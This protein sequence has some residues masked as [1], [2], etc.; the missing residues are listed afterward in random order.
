VL[1]A[2]NFVTSLLSDAG[3][4]TPPGVFSFILAHAST[5]CEIETRLLLD[6]AMRGEDTILI[7]GNNRLDA[8]GLLARARAM[9]IEDTLADGVH[10]ARAFT[11][12]QFLTLLEETLP[13][14]VHE[15]GARY[16]LVTGLLE[17]FSDEDVTEAEARV[18]VPRTLQRLTTFA[19]HAS[20]P[21]VA[22][23]DVRSRL[24]ALA[25]EHT[26]HREI[27]L[28]SN[29]AHQPRLDTFSEAG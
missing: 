5:L 12:H 6:A 23:S 25:C 29:A 26:P 14:T 16:I 24:A 15:T 27:T 8:Y 13:H 21:I 3:T 17:P 22:T 11:V 18:M 4:H 10:L 7:C 20:I 2:H 28:L 9:G 1:S 19:A